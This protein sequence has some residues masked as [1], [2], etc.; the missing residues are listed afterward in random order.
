MA[1]EKVQLMV[2]GPAA[3][4]LSEAAQL[5]SATYSHKEVS[6]CIMTSSKHTQARNT[7]KRNLYFCLSVYKL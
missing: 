5:I 2:R 1:L 7:D 4:I 3:R 6:A